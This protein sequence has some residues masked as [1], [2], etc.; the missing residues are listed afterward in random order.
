MLVDKTVLAILGNV[1]DCM[2]SNGATKETVSLDIN[3]TL[4]NEIYSFTGN[5]YSL[6]ELQKAAD[7]CLAHEWI[8]RTTISE[9]Y[10]HLAITEKGLGV[11]RSKRKQEQ[12][13]KSRKPLKKISDY[14]EDH[15]GLFLL[16]GFA[17]TLASLILKIYM[18]K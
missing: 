2:E 1:V 6:G 13:W 18:D 10:H 8:K 9:K 17:V 12:V 7:M 5:Q 14:I 15:K 16:L 11:I 4:V 3:E